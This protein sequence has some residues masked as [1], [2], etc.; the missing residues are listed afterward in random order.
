MSGKKRIALSPVLK[1]HKFIFDLMKNTTSDYT[2]MMDPVADIFLVSPAFV[3]AYGLPAETMQHAA[4]VLCP[5]V[6][7]QDRKS[8]ERL[9]A[10]LN[11]SPEDRYTNSKPMR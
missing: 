8:L 9:F 3:Q 1:Q 2:F 4:D 10:S 5:L 7:M 6:Y 11:H